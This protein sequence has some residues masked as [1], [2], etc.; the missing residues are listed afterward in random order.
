MIRKELL[1]AKREKQPKKFSVPSLL[2]KTH[3]SPDYCFALV[4]RTRN[5]GRSGCSDPPRTGWRG[6]KVAQRVTGVPIAPGVG[7]MGW[8]QRWER[9]INDHERR[10]R[11]TRVSREA[12]ELCRPYGARHRFAFYPGLTPCRGPQ[13]AR[14]SRVGWTR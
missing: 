1:A 5:F 12:I 4:A 6:M 9:L 3:V 13:R 10:R 8:G 14:F 7:A 2:V 11:G